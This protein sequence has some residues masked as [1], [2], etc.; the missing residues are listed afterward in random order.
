MLIFLTK[1]II[2]CKAKLIVT[3]SECEIHFE[4]VVQVDHIVFQFSKIF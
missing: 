1:S 2:C 4:L 3:G